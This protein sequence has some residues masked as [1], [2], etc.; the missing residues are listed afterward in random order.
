MAQA[1]PIRQELEHENKE[2][3]RLNEAEHAAPPA[4]LRSAPTQRIQPQSQQNFRDVIANSGNALIL[5]DAQCSVVYCNP[6]A[7]RMLG[8]MADELIGRPALELV[9][10]NDQARVSELLSGLASQPGAVEAM[11]F[12]CLHKD[13]SWRWIEAMGSNALSTPGVDALVIHYR[14]VT[15]RRLAQEKLR[16]SETRLQSLIENGSDQVAILTV[17]GILIYESPSARP[18]LL[19]PDGYLLGREMWELIHPDDL[20]RIK[21][22][23]ELLIENADMVLRDQFRLQRSDRT[24]RWVEG[25]AT[26]LLA[27]PSVHGIVLNYH[28]ITERKQAAETLREGETMLR[29]F[30]EQ[31]QDAILITDEQGIVVEWSP[32]AAKLTGYSREQ[33]IGKALWDV[34]YR[35]VAEGHRSPLLRE[36]IKYAL[37]SALSTGHSGVLNTVR[38]API[39][40]PDGT[41][42]ITQTIAFSIPTDKGYRLGVILRDVTEV[43]QTEHALRHSEEQYRHIVETA[44]EG[45]VAWDENWRVSFANR[46]AAEILGYTQEEM[47]GK[48]IYDFIFEAD[49]PEHKEIQVQREQGIGGTSQRAYRTKSGKAVWLQASVSP[50]LE[51]GKFAGSY[52]L[53][54][55]ITERKQGEEKL[56]QSQRELAEAQRVARIGS[57]SLD[58]ETGVGRWSDEMYEI[59]GTASSV[60]T[61]SYA[62]FERLI[63]PDDAA[64]VR[65]AH[66]HTI[67]T[68]E[69]FRIEHRIIT[70]AG[71]VRTIAEI[72]HAVV[73]ANGK[74]TGLFGTAQ[75]ITERKRAEASLR[76]S[77]ER[78]RALYEGSPVSLW[79]EDF[80]QVKLL[81]D[82]L[83]REGVTDFRG[84]FASHPEFIK[85]C[86]EGVRITDVNRATLKLFDAQDKSLFLGA[87]SRFVNDDGIRDFE[88][89]LVNIAEGRRQFSW[90]GS[91]RT[92]NGRKLDILL[93]WSVVPGYEETLSKVL[94]FIEDVTDRKHAEE[95]SRRQFKRLLTLRE[96]DSAITSS[97][98]ER[99][100]LNLLITRLVSALGV[101][102]A[103]VLLLNR[104][105][106]TLSFAAGYG[107]SSPVG[108]LE[109]PITGTYAGD[110][111][112]D[113]RI[114][115]EPDLQ[116][117]EQPFARQA[118]AAREGFKSY[119]GIPLVAKGEVKGVLEIFHR[120]RLTPDAEWLDFLE[121]FASQAAIAIDNAQL[122]EGLQRSNFELG[123][124]YDSTIEGWSKA[125][126]L[127]DKET[128]GHTQ[129]VTEMAVELARQF[130]F[131]DED[132]LQVRRG[133]L[134]HDI[135]KMGV[136]DAILFKPGP[137]S[138]ADWVVMKKHPAFAYQLLSPIRYLKAAAVEIP[139]CHHE[140]WDGTGY[141]RGLKGEQIPLSARIFSVIDVWDALISDRPYRPAWP[142]EKA[143]AYIVEQA[144]TQFDPQV[145][146]SFMQMIDREPSAGGGA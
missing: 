97:F 111:I 99:F 128:E 80:S 73:D 61:D 65:H 7:S 144:A 118:L 25:V 90:E 137:L 143:R 8:Y 51:G 75:D 105:L 125:L 16:A 66:E 68:G 33:S 50:V 24:W 102:A 130:G 30:L 104:Y 56:A 133:A 131:N 101:D 32:G 58:L 88:E 124:A 91:N 86:L 82:G 122:F 20:P 1:K 35:A 141:P 142:G 6:S 38:E 78:Y 22:E 72:G 70:S 76:E 62:M 44:H 37:Q 64:M 17:D 92:L 132:I 54:S 120:A 83:R 96:I 36:D 26:N 46:R 9:H 39:Q 93:R 136:P 126:D 60:P 103:D 100:T 85:A 18:I 34:Q 63:Y 79:E 23:F 138:E 134:L 55:D 31:S 14:D 11:E 21:G 43:K 12:R 115:A 57:W 107:F 116:K 95:Q 109:L 98:D 40:R 110:V 59:F 27:E 48:S 106:N 74:V 69:P 146:K 129:R 77:E 10:R 112:R 81:L 45:I 139:Y 29:G 15:D 89:E 108:S 13:G 3:S 41:R 94:V 87:V 71:D 123:I 145:V 84:Y 127:R 114:V 52:T 67:S 2:L 117:A 140:R 42:V 113:R 5:L 19:Y 121:T 4:G 49:H 135:G 119:Y 53:I 47:Q 28:D